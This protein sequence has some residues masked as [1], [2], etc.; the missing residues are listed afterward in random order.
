VNSPVVSNDIEGT[1]RAAKIAGLYSDLELGTES[2]A[3]GVTRSPLDVVDADCQSV[4]R[5]ADPLAWRQ[6]VSGL[7]L[8]FEAQGS[9]GNAI[10]TLDST[11]LQAATW[12]VIQFS[13][14][15]TRTLGAFPDL[16]RKNPL[17]LAALHSMERVEI[18]TRRGKQNFFFQPETPPTQLTNKDLDR[19]RLKKIESALL[20][21]G[22]TLSSSVIALNVRYHVL[23]PDEPLNSSNFVIFDGT[24]RSASIS[25]RWLD[26]LD[27]S[28]R[29]DMKF[30]GLVLRSVARS[31]ALYTLM[32]CTCA[33]KPGV[34][35]A[36][37][38]QSLL[39]GVVEELRI[40]SRGFAKREWDEA[41][42]D[43]P[44]L[45]RRVDEFVGL[46][47]ALMKDEDPAEISRLTDGVAERLGKIDEAVQDDRYHALSIFK[48]VGLA[49]MMLERSG[50]RGGAI[51]A[52][53]TMIEAIVAAQRADFSGPNQLNLQIL[54]IYTLLFHESPGRF[55]KALRIL[56]D[57]PFSDPE[58]D[59]A[60]FARRLVGTDKSLFFNLLAHFGQLES[61]RRLCMNVILAR[62][63]GGSP[64]IRSESVRVL[65]S[66]TD[67]FELFGRRIAFLEKAKTSI[68]E[69][70]GSVQPHTTPQKY[71]PNPPATVLHM[72]SGL[73]FWRLD[74]ASSPSDP[75]IVRIECRV[76]PD[77][78]SVSVINQSGPQ[79]RAE[80]DL[81]FRVVTVAQRLA[82]EFGMKFYDLC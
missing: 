73:G 39:Q 48:D 79:L 62:I 71:Q 22:L 82:Q 33:D 41:L 59:R 53:D 76:G 54:K 52:F 20:A 36:S 40:L 31:E 61:L 25:L 72:E 8:V 81:R 65:E 42:H 16:G 60:G 46:D 4:S 26:A 69:F 11:V 51:L 21:E 24:R 28:R 50:N 17:W 5:F 32:D 43:D 75:R 14:D 3:S 23:F 29:E 37:A 49:V 80:Y 56:L 38:K 64:S 70:I 35:Q 34:Y 67:V 15:T 19:E 44:D 7:R 55:L 78:D 1:G 47:C 10:A 68:P 30:L 77:T 66:V 12:S 57:A 18:L 2:A 74:I 27:S 6:L 9:I 58:V 45:R 63:W 13:R